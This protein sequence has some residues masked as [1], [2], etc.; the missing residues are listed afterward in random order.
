MALNPYVGKLIAAEIAALPIAA[1]AYAA[2]APAIWAVAVGAALAV[3]LFVVPIRDM[4]LW[5]W[6]IQF[7]HW[8]R[9][10]RY[11]LH[12]VMQPPSDNK[13]EEAPTPDPGSP[14]DDEQTDTAAVDRVR[15]DRFTD[16]AINDTTHVGV[17]VEDHTVVTMVALWGRPYL[18]TLLTA[19]RLRPPTRCR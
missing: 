11:H 8:V 19:N 4:T 2:G 5:Q 16:V 7:A 12:E 9:R 13:R 14:S 3:C 18:P 1:A 6:A 10:R 17:L 15:K